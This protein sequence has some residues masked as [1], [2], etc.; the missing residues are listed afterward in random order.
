MTA[1]G[2]THAFEPEL[3]IVDAHHHVRDRPGDSYL[4]ADLRADLARGHKVLAT[5]A[6]ECG[7]MYRAFGPV[8]MRPVGETEFLAGV[9]AMFASGRYGPRLACAAIVGHADLRL[10][11][12][13]APVLDALA[14]ASGGRLRGIRN[15]V[16]W[17]PDAELRKTRGGADGVLRE[18]RFQE[19]VALLGP[20]GLALDAW[21]YHPQLPEVAALARRCPQTT[22]VLDH[23]GGPLG[24]GPYAGRVREAFAEWRALLR[25]VAREPNVV[26]KIGG[27]GLPIMGLDL[28]ADATPADVASRWRPYVETA[29]ECFGTNRCMF[30]SNY[31]SDRDEV[32]YVDVWNAFKLLTAHASPAERHALFAGTAIAVYGLESAFAA[33]GEPLPSAGD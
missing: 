3:P 9:A 25:E 1:T 7:D 15:P 16:A 6:I 19:G 22:I 31:P 24:R 5:V 28:P 18:A 4:F 21:V 33:A 26:C 12:G 17:H 8:A 27:L 2:D 30:E 13:A 23:L 20:R 29:V 11:A 32:S 14:G 10:G